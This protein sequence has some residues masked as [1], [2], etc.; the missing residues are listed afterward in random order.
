MCYVCLNVCVYSYECF[1]YVFIYIHKS[2]LPVIL[3]SAEISQFFSLKIY[4]R[5]ETEC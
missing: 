2:V 3:C 1:V 5:I 4:Q